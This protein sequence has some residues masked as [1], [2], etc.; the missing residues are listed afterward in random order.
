MYNDRW[1]TTIVTTSRLRQNGQH[2]ADDILK[3]NFLYENCY[4]LLHNSL[5]LVPKAPVDKP[6]SGPMMNQL[7]NAYMGPQTNLTVQSTIIKDLWVTL[8]QGENRSLVWFTFIFDRSSQLLKLYI[9]AK[10]VQS[11][12]N[13]WLWKPSISIKWVVLLWDRLSLVP[14]K[15]TYYLY[16]HTVQCGMTGVWSWFLVICDSI[17]Y[18]LML[19]I[20]IIG[21]EMCCRNLSAV[22]TA[23]F[24]QWNAIVYLRFTYSHSEWMHGAY[25]ETFMWC[26]L[27]CSGWG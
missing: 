3:S 2:F 6:L 19:Q 16:Y 18:Y 9:K 13:V 24:A 20:H 10:A 8:L 14:K 15:H 11:I 22:F 12:A 7:T 17:G 4:I 23:M 1:L 27:F 25:Q 21:I 26:V 5:K